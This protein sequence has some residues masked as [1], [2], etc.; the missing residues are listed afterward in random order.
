MDSLVANNAADDDSLAADA[1]A[2]EEAPAAE[3][4]PEEAPAA[5]T[6]LRSLVVETSVPKHS[7]L[8]VDSI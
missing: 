1:A 4:A 2:V 8:E 3:A 5:R 6:L 7:D